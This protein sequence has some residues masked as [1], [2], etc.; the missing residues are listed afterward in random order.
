MNAMRYV[1]PFKAVVTAQN[2]LLGEVLDII[3]SQW[4]KVQTLWQNLVAV[5]TGGEIA[6]QMPVEAKKFKQIDKQ[7]K[8]I[9]ERAH[10]QKKVIQCCTND[11]LKSQLG[12]LQE[13]LLFCQQRLDFYL[14][15]KRGI[16]ARFYFVSPDDLLQILSVGSDPHKVQDDFQKL[17]EDINKV[18]FDDND[19]RL[20]TEII[21]VMEPDEEVIQLVEGVTAV[22]NIEDWMVLLEKEMVRSMKGQC[23]RGSQEAK[24][25][26]NTFEFVD[27]FP[28]QV[29]LLG[30][31]IV[32]TDKVT[33]SLERSN[34][35]DRLAEF[36]KNK[37]TLKMIMDD[38]TLICLQEMGK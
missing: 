19:R 34:Y 10:E 5:F 4:L 37:K 26:I 6:K 9:M 25:S 27:K 18:K 23:F 36:D 28:S 17:F 38:L 11:I 29:A 16:F 20:I 15:Q 31:Q 8:Q 14:E 32:W 22:G 24:A 33:E 2:E 13:G 3:E 12:V 35:K 7:W 1:T 30:I 21:S